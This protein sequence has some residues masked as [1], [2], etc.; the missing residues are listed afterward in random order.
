[1]RVSG[2]DV[3]LY[4]EIFGQERSIPA[5]G[6]SIDR[7]PT[8]IGL[9]GGPGLDGGKLRYLLPVLADIAPGV[10]PDQ[11]RHGLSDPGSPDQWNLARWAADVKSFAD[12]LGIE[13]PIVL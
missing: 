3:A 5:D 10:V 8:L 4:F 7:H 11:R 2:G 12:P 9:H 1:M 6:T 13:K